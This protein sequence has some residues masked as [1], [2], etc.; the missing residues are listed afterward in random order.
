[1]E[2]LAR[3]NLS[4]QLVQILGNQIIRNEL[5]SGEMIYETK[6]SKE[7]GVSR[8]PV[9]DALH[10]LEQNRLLERT[11]SGSYKVTEL[12]EEYILN[13]YDTVTIIYQ[14]VF[15]KAAENATK[16]EIQAL[17]K[18]LDKI[19]KSLETKDYEI[20]LEG[21]TD[22]GKMILAAARNPI[23]EKIA[24]ELMPSAQRIQYSTLTIFPDY[25]ETMVD[26]IRDSYQHIVDQNPGAAARDFTHFADALKKIHLENLIAQQRIG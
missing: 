9:R 14:Y 24:L 2:Q 6:I 25:F 18:A 23:V 21:F 16:K 19:E 20:Y 12:T 11:A 22:Y 15:A 7:W 17:K 1:M 5:K 26:L 3:N 4:D 10:M 8:S 13:F